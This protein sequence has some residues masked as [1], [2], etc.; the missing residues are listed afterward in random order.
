MDGP[1]SASGLPFNVHA[2]QQHAKHASLEDTVVDVMALFKKLPYQT[3]PGSRERVA[4]DMA[5]AAGVGVARVRCHRATWDYLAA[6]VPEHKKGGFSRPEDVEDNVFCLPANEDIVAET[7]G[8]V[9]VP[10]AGS[11]LASVLHFC[12]NI[13]DWP[14]EPNRA[15]NEL[16]KAIGRRV[17]AAISQALRHVVPSAN[18]SGPTAVVYLDDKIAAVGT[19]A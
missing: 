7:D 19:T 2:G 3:W 14:Y 13:Q 6:Q 10:P 9:T 5:K 18:G 12:A 1:G 4:G 16:D 11:S 8:I 15:Y 17:G